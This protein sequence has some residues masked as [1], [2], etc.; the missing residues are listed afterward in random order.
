MPMI[1]T[2]VW[3]TNI[4]QLPTAVLHDLRLHQ[5]LPGDLPDGRKHTDPDIAISTYNGES[6]GHWEGDSLVV[7]HQVPGAQ[8]ALDRS[9]TADLG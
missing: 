7:E 2:R 3:P 9:G 8:R 4:I 1:M 6:I 5:Q